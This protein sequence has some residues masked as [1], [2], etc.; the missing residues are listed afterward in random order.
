MQLKVEEKFRRIPTKKFNRFK[1]KSGK[2]KTKKTFISREKGKN[3]REEKVNILLLCFN[4]N[5]N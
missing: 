5:Y 2:S 3:E 4:Y 1:K